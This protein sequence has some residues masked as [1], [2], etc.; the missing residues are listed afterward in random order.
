[1]NASSADRFRRTTLH[2]LFICTGNICRSPT[3]ERLAE[4]YAERLNM[5]D[6]SAS[7]AG[8]RAVIGHP[9]QSAAATVLHELGGDASNFAA[10]QL[11]AKIAAHAELVITMTKAHRDAVLE[12]A[13]RQ[14]RRTYTLVEA[15]RLASD[16]GAQEVHDL[17]ALRSQLPS[18]GAWDITDPIGQDE[19]VFKS[20]GQQIADLLPPVLDLCQRSA[21]IR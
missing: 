21:S 3:A 16:F 14:L 18:E 9:V 20:V 4:V 6:F 5:S 13:P 10:R 11:T 8:T 7:S 19:A 15:S 12:I 17:A 2:V 1:M